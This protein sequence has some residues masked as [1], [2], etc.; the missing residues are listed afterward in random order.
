[1]AVHNLTYVERLVAGAREA[2]AAGAYQTYADAIR[3]G[4]APWE[5]RELISVS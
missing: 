5:A 1:M 3:G 4:R 2:I